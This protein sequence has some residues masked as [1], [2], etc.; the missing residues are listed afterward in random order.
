MG[1]ESATQDEA[2][3]M[4]ASVA[5][6]GAVLVGGAI[7]EF[8]SAATDEALGTGASVAT[9]GTVLVGRA[10]AGVAPLWEIRVEW[11]TEHTV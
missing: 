5:T 4:R 11:T 1:F 9:V 8:E 7:V 6:V 10:S 2:L 3:G